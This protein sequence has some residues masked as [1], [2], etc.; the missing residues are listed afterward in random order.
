MSSTVHPDVHI[1]QTCVLR[2]H[3]WQQ[4]AVTLTGQSEVVE[5]RHVVDVNSTLTWL[6][7]HDGAGGLPLTETPGG[8]VG[9]KLGFTF[10]LGKSTAEIVQV[11]PI[12]L[13][14]ISDILSEWS[15]GEIENAFIDV[16]SKLPQM[17]V[18]EVFVVRVLLE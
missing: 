18:Q 13:R 5:H 15:L 6:H 10:L 14:D 8:T 9:V 2:D 4:D 17:I 11:Q 12:K 16:L 7:T 1:E 3:E